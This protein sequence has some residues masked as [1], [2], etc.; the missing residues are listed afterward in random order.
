M[1][2]QKRNFSEF[3]I[4]SLVMAI[5]SFVTLLGIEKAF[6]ALAFGILALLRIGKNG[7]LRGKGLAIAGILL[8]GI[9]VVLIIIVAIRYLPQVVQTPQSVPAK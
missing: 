9:A 4:A 1:E 8:A 5:L 3:A 2:E 7:Q 6:A